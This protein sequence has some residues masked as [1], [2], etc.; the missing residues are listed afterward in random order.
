MDSY[1]N[2]DTLN[3]Q[4]D[5]LNQSASEQEER[6]D[7]PDVIFTL[8]DEKYSISSKY[9]L[10]IEV[11]PEITPMAGMEPHCRGIIIFN[12]QSVP[13]YDMRKIFD[14]SNFHEE[15][16]AMM[17]QR[18]EDH[19]HWVNALEDSVR[20]GTEFTLTTD[21]HE[22]AFGKWYDSF[23]TDNSYLSMYLKSIEA[24]HS[25]I[26]KTGETVKKLM[27]EG[28]KEEA[29]KVI[30][31]MKATDFAKTKKLLAN[32][33]TIYQEGMREMLIIMQVGDELKSMVVDS[34]SSIKKLTDLCELPP[35]MPYG[36]SQY[37]ERLAKDYHD[38]KMDVILMLNPYELA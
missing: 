15:L 3:A 12:D 34:I 10:H 5:E 30:N 35:N 21:P 11:L 4:I 8:Q 14:I 38:D 32:I 6:T 26:H 36:K 25:A 13:V 22:C 1:E 20:Q 19:E 33:S 27:A 9:V 31:E 18:I 24:P 28:K 23:E 37:V 2:N 29:E 17:H 16:E 7:L